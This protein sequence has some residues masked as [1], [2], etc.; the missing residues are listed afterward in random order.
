MVKM[1][2]IVFNLFQILWKCG[3]YIVSKFFLENYMNAVFE[4]DFNN[5]RGVYL[6]LSL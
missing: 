1:G 6:V 5:Y 2:L 3:K 4:G